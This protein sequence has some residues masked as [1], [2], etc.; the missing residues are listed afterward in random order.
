M[1][2]LIERLT[3]GC[4]TGACLLQ[5]GS[6]TIDPDIP[7]RALLTFGSDVAIFLLDNLIVSL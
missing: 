1:R 7:F 4:L 5:A 3:W 2:K 6:C